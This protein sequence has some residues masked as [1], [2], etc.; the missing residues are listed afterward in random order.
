M[1]L[2]ETTPVPDSALPL[3]AFKAHLRLGTGFGEDSLQDAVLLAF[4]RA[5]LAAVEGRTGKALLA[6]TFEWRLNAWPATVTLPVAPV[7]DVSQVAMVGPT[8]AET[9]LPAESYSVAPDSHAP[10]LEPLSGQFPAVPTGGGVLLRFAAGLGETWD[11]LPADLAQAVFLLAAHYYEYRDDT[12][13]HA[14]CMP[15]GVAS[16]LDRHRVPRLSL[17]RSAGGQR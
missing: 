10:R 12:S 17:G 8:G 1:I 2:H 15:F 7:R 6:R 5:S 9:V 3:E 16:L 13:L 4:L 11:D 14:G